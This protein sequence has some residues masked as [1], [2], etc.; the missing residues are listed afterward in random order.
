M[1]QLSMR[2]TQHLLVTESAWLTALGGRLWVTR[3]GDLNDYVLEPGQRLA[4]GRGDDVTVGGWQRD[5]PAL[6]DW[7]PM[8]PARRYG[9]LR[10][11]VATAFGAAARALR[12]AAEGLSALAR[13]AASIACRAEGCPGR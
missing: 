8:A 1:S 7:A 2:E 5:Q 4:L 6:W 13:N 10:A 3:R 12:G 11:L 9:L